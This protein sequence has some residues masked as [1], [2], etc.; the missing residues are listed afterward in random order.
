M[1]TGLLLLILLA[2]C[3]G[4][5]R[6]DVISPLSLEGSLRVGSD[7]GRV[8]VS[9]Y[10][11]PGY[12][13]QL[14]YVA[15]LG[16]PWSTLAWSEDGAGEAIQVF[17]D[18]LV[19]PLPGQSFVRVVATVNGNDSDGDGVPDAFDPTPFENT[20]AAF[21]ETSGLVN[22]DATVRLADDLWAVWTFDDATEIP[23]DPPGSR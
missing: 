16:A 15:I 3:V 6:A 5:G 23:L 19:N 13:Y 8:A 21:P 1:K 20:F 10:G 4:P 22:R 2:W 7:G 18:E 11:Q 9:W 14:E 12:T 17:L